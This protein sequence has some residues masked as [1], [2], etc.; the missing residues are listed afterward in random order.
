[1][2]QERLTA[3]ERAALR[4]RIVQMP[5]QRPIMAQA[6]VLRTIRTRRAMIAGAGALSF[7][8][9]TASVSYA[10]EY[11]LPGDTLY[12]VKVHVNEGVIRAL[13]QT[14]EKK[15]KVAEQEI[16]RR[17]QEIEALEQQAALDPDLTSE[18]KGKTQ[19]SLQAFAQAT[20]TLGASGKTQEAKERDRSLHK[21]IER[22]K[23]ALSVVGV[24]ADDRREDRADREEEKE[25]RAKKRSTAG[26]QVEESP[27]RSSAD[28]IM[29]APSTTT[30]ILQGTSSGQ[31]EDRHEDLRE[32]K[33][34]DERSDRRG[35]R[36]AQRAAN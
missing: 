17:A 4:A 36:P 20:S 33:E 31:I 3:S 7:F 35:D 29:S 14:P 2:Q 23:K 6:S 12:P 5:L 24:G 13:A 15:A 34:E 18:L 21:T 1:M 16:E 32:D 22:H 26:D 28:T 9:M 10:A 11:A 8:V 30:P 25:V 19:R 27:R